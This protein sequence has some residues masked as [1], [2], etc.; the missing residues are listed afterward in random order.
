[1]F[2]PQIGMFWGGL[3]WLNH[4]DTTEPFHDPKLNMLIRKG[5]KTIATVVSCEY[6]ATAKN[7][8]EIGLRIR[9]RKKQSKEYPYDDIELVDNTGCSIVHHGVP[10]FQLV[11]K[12]NTPDGESAQNLCHNIIV[13]SEIDVK[14]GDPLP[15]LYRIYREDAI[16][17]VDSMPFPLPL[18]ELVDERN[19][20]YSSNCLNANT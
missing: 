2:R 13:H 20:F 7:D 8:L 15:I 4:T 14:P 9:R 6:L 3:H 18:H 19:I 11:Y 10:S 17:H 1:M 16:E 5:Q 12:F